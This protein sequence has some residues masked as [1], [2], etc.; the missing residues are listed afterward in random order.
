MNDDIPGLHLVVLPRQPDETRP[1]LQ[2]DGT[3][4]PPWADLRDLILGPLGEL[5]EAVV[6]QRPDVRTR[7]FLV[8]TPRAP[9]CVYC[10]F[11]RREATE[12][13]ESIIAGVDVWDR[14]RAYE[15]NGDVGG[16]ESGS[17][18]FSE[19]H[20]IHRDRDLLAQTVAEVAESLARR[21]DIVVAAVDAAAGVPVANLYRWEPTADPQPEPREP[22]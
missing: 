9:L 2:D 7:M 18:A 4:A 10:E 16:E 19:S 13:E 14:D 15:I 22:A 11:R 8:S 12:D 21:V 6:K 20:E 1:R 17:I 5:R 3:L